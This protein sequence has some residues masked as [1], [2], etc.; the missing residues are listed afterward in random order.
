[1]KGRWVR[2]AE[3]LGVNSIPVVGVL[4]GDWSAATALSVYWVENLI[5]SLLIAAR[6]ALHARW[7]DRTQDPIVAAGSSFA[8]KSAGPF[9]VTALPFTL[10]HGLVL[11]FIFAM[12]LELTPDLADLRRAVVALAVVQGITFGIDLWTLADWPVARV[13]ERADYLL[14]RVVLVHLS[15]IAGMVLAAWLER[16]RA[17]FVFFV[18]CKV[19]SDLTQLLPRV[20]PGTPGE[21]PRW[22]SRLMRHFPKQKG[23]TF[24]EY[25]RR[26]NLPPGKKAA[27]PPRWRHKRRKR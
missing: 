4:A 20:D 25:W 7:R 19:L 17:F 11:A 2:V 15:I 1:M 3:L 26:T 14:G 24:D 22:L 9:L 27:P 10:A 5:A 18:G 13:N 16:P 6:L 21:P 12:V 23:E 8:P